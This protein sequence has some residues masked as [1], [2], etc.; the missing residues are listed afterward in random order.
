MTFFIR[1]FISP[2]DLEVQQKFR[3]MYNLKEFLQQ[4]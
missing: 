1:I 3:P 2:N 4:S